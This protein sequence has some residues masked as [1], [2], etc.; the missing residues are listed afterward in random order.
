M[1]S[2]PT[3]ARNHLPRAIF[4]ATLLKALHTLGGYYVACSVNHLHSDPHKAYFADSGPV[5][6]RHPVPTLSSISRKTA[7]EQA[8]PCLSLRLTMVSRVTEVILASLHSSTASFSSNLEPYSHK[9]YA[10]VINSHGTTV[11]V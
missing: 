5:L 11:I 10:I 8:L 4:L 9:I 7:L 2:K 6:E 3:Q 1:V